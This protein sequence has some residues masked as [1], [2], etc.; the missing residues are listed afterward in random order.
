MGSDLRTQLLVDHLC[1]IDSRRA[2]FSE[3]EDDGADRPCMEAYQR[4]HRAGQP[5]S[6]GQCKASSELRNLYLGNPYGCV[7][8][9]ESKGC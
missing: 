1:H 6:I 4:Q 9:I 3:V 7:E 5:C 8:T 2:V